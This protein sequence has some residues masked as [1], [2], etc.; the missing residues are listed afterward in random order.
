MTFERPKVTMSNKFQFDGIIKNVR[1]HACLTSELQSYDFSGFDI[2][3][4][5]PY[6]LIKLP[7]EQL[8]YSRWDTPSQ[9]KFFPFARNY[10]AYAGPRRNIVVIPVMKDGGADGKLEH[11]Q[12]ATLSWMN[13]ANVYI[14]LAYYDDA[15]VNERG[16][17]YTRE[18]FVNQR[19]NTEI[20]NSQIAQLSH[21]HSAAIHWNRS[22]FGDRFKSIYRKAIQAYEKM[23]AKTKVKIYPRD[24]KLECIEKM[25][26][27][28]RKYE[29]ISIDGL[30]TADISKDRGLHE[31]KFTETTKSVFY[32]I[33]RVGGIYYL[34]AKDVW[35]LRD[36]FIIQETR[37]SNKTLLPSIQQIRD[38]LFRL[39]LFQNID[40]LYRNGHQIRFQ[41]RL[42]LLGNNVQG[43]L[44]LPC[45][46][47]DFNS[48]V[49]QNKSVISKDEM[50]ILHK[51]RLETE[52]NQYLIVEVGPRK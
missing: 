39:I 3:K 44:Y 7:Y 49:R 29:G 14:V 11:I 51:L 27:A 31:N 50:I 19:L 17:E 26:R 48:F 38:G 28:C 23:S 15:D 20:V 25:R 24:V 21:Y 43:T 52:K 16:N 8:G 30:K 18:K 35:R 41:S 13:L 36:T 46:D 45:K 5:N 47:K 40:S 1:Y 10:G 9:D 4:V 6:G 34:T 12:Y 22:L 2:N 32:L 33:D 42:S 37:F